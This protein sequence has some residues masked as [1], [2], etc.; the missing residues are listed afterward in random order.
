AAGDSGVEPKLSTLRECVTGDTIVCL[1]DGRRLPIRALVGTTPEVVAVRD[2][3]VVAARS[4]LVWSV[5]KRPVFR[6]VLASG[7]TIHATAEHRLHAFGEWTCVKDLRPGDRI[8]VARFLP[9]PADSKSW[10][11]LRLALL[12]QLIGDGSYLAGKPLRYTTSSVD[13]SEIVAKAAVEEFGSPVTSCLQIDS[14]HQLWISGNGSRWHPAGVNEWLR[15][16]GVFGQRSYE[17]RVPRNVFAL[18][19]RDVSILLRHLWATDGSIDVSDGR[20]SVYY[21]T[22]SIG[23]A[24]DVAALLLRFGI[25]TR[26]VTTKDEK[27]GLAYQVHVCGAIDQLLFLNAIGTFGP[28]AKPGLEL[29]AALEGIVANTNVDTIPREVFDKVRQRMREREI[30]TPAIAAL[31]GT[32]YGGTSHFQFAPSRTHLADYARLLEDDELLDIATNHL[33]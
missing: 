26:T 14:W 30:T 15:D 27:Y 18:P 13:N 22:N 11:A 24:K 2:G 8:A 31:R 6:V 33:F 4:D 20:G 3:R 28:R 23:L 12:G 9:E 25:V 1:T 7:R 19:N 10:P 5:G 29:R 21:A 32:S 17:K 16:L